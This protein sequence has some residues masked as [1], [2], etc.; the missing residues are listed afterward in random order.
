MRSNVSVEDCEA[1]VFMVSSE[2]PKHFVSVAGEE[3]EVA[4]PSVVAED[5]RDKED[6]AAGVLDSAPDD[7]ATDE[8]RQNPVDDVEALLEDISTHSMACDTL[9]HSVDNPYGE[10]DKNVVADDDANETLTV[11]EDIKNS[12]N[13]VKHDDYVTAKKVVVGVKKYEENANGDANTDDI[14]FEGVAHS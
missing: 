11:A 2:S 9:T 3:E 12:I 8:L 4:V 5:F 1:I 13:D 14:A 6:R 10:M 7:D